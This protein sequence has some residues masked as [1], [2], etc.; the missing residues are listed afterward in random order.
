[1]MMF[2]GPT[3]ERCDSSVHDDNFDVNDERLCSEGRVPMGSEVIESIV[4]SG[5]CSKDRRF[6]IESSETWR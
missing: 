2:I 4:C 3:C 6:Y 5:E 1:M